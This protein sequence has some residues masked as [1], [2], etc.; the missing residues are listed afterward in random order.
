MFINIIRRS[1]K[2]KIP[3]YPFGIPLIARVLYLS[4]I[5]FEM[6]L[7]RK[8]KKYV[9]NKEKLVNIIHGGI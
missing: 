3:R 2:K 7:R 5:L 9:H 8:K 6:Y 1:K 4:F